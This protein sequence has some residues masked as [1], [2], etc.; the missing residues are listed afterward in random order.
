VTTVKQLA[1]GKGKAT[2]ISGDT[3]G[4]VRIWDQESNG[5]VSWLI[6]NISLA[7][8][9]SISAPPLSVPILHPL[10]LRWGH[11]HICKMVSCRTTSSRVV[12]TALYGCGNWRAQQVGWSTWGNVYPASTADSVEPVQ[13]QKIDL[14]G[15]LPLDIAVAYLPGSHGQSWTTG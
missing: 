1:K 9:H 2:L 8:F 7:N 10:S 6:Q 5:Q 12:Q 13:V 4:D 3:L 14:K 15:Q 11:H